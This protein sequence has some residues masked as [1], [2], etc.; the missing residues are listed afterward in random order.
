MD[1]LARSVRA[2]NP[3]RGVRATGIV[4]DLELFKHRDHQGVGS[5]RRDIHDEGGGGGESVRW[6]WGLFAR[7]RGWWCAILAW[8]GRSGKIFLGYALCNITFMN[9]GDWRSWEASFLGEACVVVDEVVNELEVVLGVGD[10]TELFGGCLEDGVVEG[11]GSEVVSDM[12]YVVAREGFDV[13]D[14]EVGIL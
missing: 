10:N 3:F 9:V 14:G 11:H 7:G 13:G 5:A 6:E 2:H 4:L 1:V 12:F 8:G